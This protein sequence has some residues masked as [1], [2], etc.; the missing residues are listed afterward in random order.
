MKMPSFKLTLLLL[1]G[2]QGAWAEEGDHPLVSRYPGSKL[3]R[4]ESRDYAQYDLV[5]NYDDSSEQLSG[6]SLH[7]RVTRIAYYN[8]E[9]RSVLEIY[10]NYEQA[11]K[12]ADAEILYTCVNTEC[13]PSWASSK[14]N[15]FNGISTFT[16]REARYV[17]ARLMNAEGQTGYVAIMVGQRRHSIDIVEIQEMESELVVVDADALGKALDIRGYAV[18]E[19]IFFDT[20]A[21]V[22]KEDSKPALAEVAALLKK[23]PALKLY[24][25]GHTDMTGS[26]EHNLDLSRERAKAVVDALVKGYGIAATRLEGH[27]VGPLSPL[28]SNLSDGGRARNRR[29]VLVAR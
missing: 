19:G 13:A 26:L 14:W 24:V 5:T 12:A 1:L 4:T 11:L 9:D 25:V 18:V 27:G 23:K 7:G 21:A 29:V 15:R 3:I 8:P 10:K 20:D 22:L 16:P 28:A 6:K 2:F 17:A